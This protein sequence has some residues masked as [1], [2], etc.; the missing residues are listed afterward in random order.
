M[1]IG[2]VPLR[3]WQDSP[4]SSSSDVPQLARSHPRPSPYMPPVVVPEVPRPPVPPAGPE[5]II[6]TRARPNR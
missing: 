5:G 1:I 4:S 6:R 2:D 3:H